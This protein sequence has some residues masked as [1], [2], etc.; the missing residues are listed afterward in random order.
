MDIFDSHYLDAK[1]L[2][3]VISKKIIKIKKRKFIEKCLFEENEHKFFLNLNKRKNWNI[4]EYLISCVKNNPEYG[5]I[6]NLY[7]QERSIK[8]KKINIKVFKSGTEE[9]IQNFYFFK[10]LVQDKKDKIYYK[11]EFKFGHITFKKNYD[12]HI[13]KTLK[14]KTKRQ[15]KLDE[16]LVCKKKQPF[17]RVN[18]SIIK[19][20][21]NLKNITET[22]KESEI[23]F[24]TYE[25][26]IC[27]QP[28]PSCH[29][30]QKEN[31]QSF[32]QVTSN[33]DC[34]ICFEKSNYLFVLKSCNHGC[35]LVCWQNY[36]I[37]CKQ[38]TCCFNNCDEKLDLDLLR[39]ILSKQEFKKHL[40]VLFEENYNRCPK[41]CG[42]YFYKINNFKFPRCICGF[43]LC[44]EC[45]ADSHFP[46]NCESF[47][48]YLN[49]FEKNENNCEKIIFKGKFCPS[50]QVFIEKIGGCSYMRCIC[51]IQ[52][53]WNCL[54]KVYTEHNNCIV[55]DEFTIAIKD[56]DSKIKP[57][58]I[59]NY[60]Y[61]SIIGKK[62]ILNFQQKKKFKFQIIESSNF[63]MLCDS[64]ISF[65]KI[66]KK[67][68]VF[69]IEQVID[70][71]FD[72]IQKVNQMIELIFA[73][74]CFYKI[75]RIKQN[76]E[77]INFQKNLIKL[78]KYFNNIVCKKSTL[79]ILNRIIFIIVKILDKIN[80]Y[81]LVNF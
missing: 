43:S 10:S 51:G 32:L 4:K 41:K 75:N 77:E 64:I 22:I 28:K 38:F 18:K 76:N 1:S 71:L 57:L 2:R 7:Y 65:F 17:Q 78:C 58:L 12:Q 47:K 48:F 8:E 6:Q 81:K 26:P 49:Y 62:I 72:L 54:Q 63:E 27:S 25:D 60:Y 55:V 5:K 70:Y 31:V 37:F 34:P 80:N 68:C 14:Q 56:L 66:E 13:I 67:N 59:Q 39:L 16:D 61:S 69:F 33:Y 30:K 74:N 35:C 11:R 29:I 73:Q 20:I 21:L 53:C 36:T 9:V 52:F 19:I 50:C 15:V 45:K 24:K 46:I 40:K 3:P 23:V 79:E 42:N 44:S